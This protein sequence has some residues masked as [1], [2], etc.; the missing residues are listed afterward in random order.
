M[1]LLVILFAI[2]LLAQVKISRPSLM[3]KYNN[4][5]GEVDLADM[6]IALSFSTVSISE[7]LMVGY[8]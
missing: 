6:L 8:L 1:L 2:K 7:I 3:K 5:V 4:S